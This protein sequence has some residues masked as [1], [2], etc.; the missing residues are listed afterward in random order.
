FKI[1][2]HATRPA[3]RSLHEAAKVRERTRRS[4]F[5]TGSDDRRQQDAGGRITPDVQE[6]E[7]AR[8]RALQPRRG[9]PRKVLLFGEESAAGVAKEEIVSDECL[10]ES[11]M[12][13]AAQLRLWTR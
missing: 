4:T 9:S 2:P 11:V 3:R 12:V 7:G 13:R 1:Q 6:P 10:E 5:L 8:R